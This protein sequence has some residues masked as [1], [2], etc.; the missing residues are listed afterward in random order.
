MLKKPGI[1]PFFKKRPK[2]LPAS[3][4]PKIRTKTLPGPKSQKI[5]E[6][7]K[8]F[9]CPQIT[10][11]GEN[12]PVFLEKASGCNVT[13]VDGNRYLDLTSAFGVAGIGHS[14]P[15]VL[16]AMK[17]QSRLMI[18]GMGDVHPN[19][20]K[21]LLAKKLSELTPGNL[22]MSIFSSTG[23]EAVE[24]A[25]KTAVMHTKKT[26]VIAFEGAYHGLGYG[27]LSVTHRQD[28]KKPFEKQIAKFG[29]FA[30]FP[31][32]RIHGNKAVEVSLRSV[33]SVFKKNRRS[34]H[35]VG[36][37]L[38]E[39]IQGRGGIMVPPPNFMKELRAFCDEA[40]ILLIA[41]EVFTGFGRTGFWFSVMRSDVIP[42]LLCVG[43]G[44]GGGFPISACIGSSRV[45]YSWGASHGDSIHTSTF[46]GWPLGCAVALAVI[47]DIE[48]NKFIDRSREMGDF[49]KKELYKLKERYSFIG[50]VRGS[51]LMIGVEFNE[52]SYGN[53]SKKPVPG[54]E[55]A[56]R[57]ITESLKR[58][59]VLL[60]SGPDHNVVSITP[61]FLITAKDIQHCVKLF[62]EILKKF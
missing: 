43:K 41:D 56:K 35:P 52:P 23:S 45:M 57:F 5:A 59:I 55:K 26:G 14:S 25:L 1:F 27:A 44:L 6:S 50:D 4:L 42:D 38:V 62:D 21:V 36:A 10:F 8:R 37:L 9:E 53:R 2:K 33:K 22:S 32:S 28:F 40:K 29:H 30:P 39:P 7:L 34:A 18:H 47:R 11:T 51:G 13:D 20:V 12:Y 49:F 60:S 61:P 16:K 3:L 17:D 31:D 48:E 24:S 19:E 46:L 15:A 54:T 58:G